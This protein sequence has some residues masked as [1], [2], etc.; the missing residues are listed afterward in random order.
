MIK[1]LLA[2]RPSDRAENATVVVERLDP[3]LADLRRAPPPPPVEAGDGEPSDLVRMAALC[4]IPALA[5]AIGALVVL[6]G[7]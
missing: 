3:I 2:P 6:S 1:Q 5:L 4:A 7:S